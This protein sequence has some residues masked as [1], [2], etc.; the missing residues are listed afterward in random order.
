VPGFLDKASDIW[1]GKKADNAGLVAEVRR[2]GSLELPA[3]AQEAMKRGFGSGGPA[4]DG[5][6]ATMSAIQTT[7]TTPFDGRDVD[8]AAFAQLLEIVA[9]SVQALEHAGL[10]RQALSGQGGDQGVHYELVWTATRRGRS[11]L[12]HGSVERELTG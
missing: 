1:A 2:L 12:E 8:D 11:A 10:V 4:A 6:Y 5:H 7:F 3:V 9:E